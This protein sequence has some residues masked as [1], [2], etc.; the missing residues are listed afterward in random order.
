L[1][2]ITNEAVRLPERVGAKVTL[3]VHV[4]FAVSELPHGVVSAKSPGLGPEK[5]TLLILRAEFPVLPTVTVW[6]TLVVPL[7]VVLKVRL[8]GVTVA[9]GPLPMPVTVTVCGLVV[10]LSVM[11]KVAVRV[12]GAVGV[13][14]TL[15]VQAPPAATEL[16][17]EFV[18]AKS[19]GLAPVKAI[20]LIAR[21]AFPVLFRVTDWGALGDATD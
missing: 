16:P 5:V 3:I 18:P 20:V 15:I 12:P 21:A 13:N 19:L 14:V 1:S 2:V 7:G 11:V 6:A 17:Q 9:M 10:A 8:A 4:L